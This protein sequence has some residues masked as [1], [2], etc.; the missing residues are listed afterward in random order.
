LPDGKSDRIV[1][2]RLR[3][4]ERHQAKAQ[5]NGST[6]VRSDTPINRHGKAKVPPGQTQSKKWPVLDL[7]EHPAIDTDT[8][9]LTLGGSCENPTTLSWLDFQQL[10]QMNDVSDFHCV[11]TWSCLDIAWRGV[12]FR[13][14]AELAKPHGKARYILCHAYDGYTTNLPLHEALKEDV[15]LVHSAQGDVLSVEH[16]GPVRMITPQLYA[17]KGAKWISAITFLEDDSPGY[18]EQRGYSNLGDPWQEDRYSS[19]DGA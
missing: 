3:Q 15:L 13:D 4:K 8:W 9:K 10:P 6:A 11:T 1:A 5:Q 2:A 16:G 7:G 18:W 19:D 12:R 17:W 14:L